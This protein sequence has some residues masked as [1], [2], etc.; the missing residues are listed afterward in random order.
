MYLMKMRMQI[1]HF[2]NLNFKL[3]F[4]E[5]T[6]FSCTVQESNMIYCFTQ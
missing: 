6:F 1:L 2:M 4:S 3:E 5:D